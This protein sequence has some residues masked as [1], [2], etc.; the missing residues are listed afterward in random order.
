MST[1]YIYTS[2]RTASKEARFTNFLDKSYNTHGTK[3]DYSNVIYNNASDSIEIICPEHGSFFQKPL[4]HLQGR[5]CRKCGGSYKKTT[6]EFIKDSI[7]IH[8]SKYSYS[9]TVYK[10]AKDKVEIICKEHGSF[11]QEPT[12]HL[13]GQ[14]CS[15]CGFSRSRMGYYVSSDDSTAND[16][17]YM[18]IIKIIGFDEEFYKIG[19]TNNYERRHKDIYYNSGMM[20]TVDYID[21]VLI[22]THRNCFLLEQKLLKKKR[23]K[24]LLYTPKIKFGG[25][26]E[27]YKL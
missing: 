1:S 4:R 12:N 14:G 9:N 2:N 15:E 22:D 25:Q 11:Y 6:Q 21:T 23:D 10:G 26:S 16:I 20:Y 8:N 5:G 27:C 3:Y 19:I 7:K 13:Q 24:G 17:W 18:Y